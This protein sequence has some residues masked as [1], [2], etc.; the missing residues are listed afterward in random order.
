MGQDV[1]RGYTR[2]LAALN[3]IMLYLKK[4][5]FMPRQGCLKNENSFYKFFLKNSI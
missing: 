3:Y 4:A 1:L 5:D 2:Q